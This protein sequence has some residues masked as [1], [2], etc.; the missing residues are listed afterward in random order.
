M[1][2]RKLYTCE[3]NSQIEKAI[4]KIRQKFYI[5]EKFLNRKCDI[6][7]LYLGQNFQ[8]KNVIYKSLQKFYI[9]EKF[10]SRKCDIENL[11]ENFIVRKKFLS[12]KI[13]IINVEVKGKNLQKTIISPFLY[14]NNATVKPGIHFSMNEVVPYCTILYRTNVNANVCR[15]QHERNAKLASKNGNTRKNSLY[16]TKILKVPIRC[17]H[18]SFTLNLG[19][20]MQICEI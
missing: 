16:Q 6:K 3:K 19:K 15:R 13:D 18:I 17:F 10:W 20:S 1:I 8:V 11:G 7:N 12:W 9:L 14:I 2:R 5:L 4:E